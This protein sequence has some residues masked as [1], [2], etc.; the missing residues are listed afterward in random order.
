MDNSPVTDLPH[1][2]AFGRSIAE[3]DRIAIAVLGV[4]GVVIVTATVAMIRGAQ[5]CVDSGGLDVLTGQK[6]GGTVYE[7]GRPKRPDRVAHRVVMRLPHDAPEARV[8]VER[9]RELLRRHEN[10]VAIDPGLVLA[11]FDADR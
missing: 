1:V 10:R 4:D 8:A 7:A 11:I 3:G 6:V 9:T 2:D 5:M